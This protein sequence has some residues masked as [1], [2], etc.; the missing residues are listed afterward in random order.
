VRVRYRCAGGGASTAP[1]YVGD[2]PLLTSVWRV[3]TARAVV[4]ELDIRPLIGPGTH[5]DR[6]ALAAAAQAAVT[7]VEAMT[8]HVTQGREGAQEVLPRPAI[9]AS[10][11]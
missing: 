10:L 9:R 11:R 4:A 5:P 7:D 1:A 2:D 8:A 6:R 3:V